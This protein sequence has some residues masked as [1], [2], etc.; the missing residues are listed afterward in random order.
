LVHSY[1][2]TEHLHYVPQVD[3]DSNHNYGS[4]NCPN[5]DEAALLDGQAVGE[6]CSLARGIVWMNENTALVCSNPGLDY[7]LA[8]DDGVLLA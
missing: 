8:V 7:T 3:F 4:V 5:W 2:A 6:V 1:F